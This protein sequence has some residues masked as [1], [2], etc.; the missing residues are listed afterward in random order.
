MATWPRP[1]IL[2]GPAPSRAQ[3]RHHHTSAAGRT[4]SEDTLQIRLTEG[5]AEVRLSAPLGA[6][7]RVV[8]ARAEDEGQVQPV[9]RLGDAV[10]SLPGDIDVENPEIDLGRPFFQETKRFVAAREWTDDGTAQ[11]R[12]YIL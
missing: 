8:I 9:E 11:I 1:G 10:T 4:F 5:F 12:Q 7:S 3:L 2:K 6:E